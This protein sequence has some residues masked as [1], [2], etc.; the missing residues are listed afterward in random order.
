M[1]TASIRA[2]KADLSKLIDA[3]LAGEE[4]VITKNGRPL[5]RLT[6]VGRRAF[7]IVILEGQIG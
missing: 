5:V 6:P 1:P 2:A 3:A 4:V 7:Q